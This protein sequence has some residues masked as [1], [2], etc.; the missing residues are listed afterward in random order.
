MAVPAPAAGFT[1]VVIASHLFSC[2]CPL[3]M[4]VGR[5]IHDFKCMFC[6]VR[7]TFMQLDLNLLT[8]FDALLEEGSVGAAADRMNLSAPAMSRALGRIRHVTGD[9]ILVR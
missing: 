4:T 3:L 7:F 1:W 2:R 5:S 8:A 9:Q 6:T